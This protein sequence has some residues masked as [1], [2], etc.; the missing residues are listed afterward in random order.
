MLQTCM[1]RSTSPPGHCDKATAGYH[2]FLENGNL[3]FAE[4]PKS[5]P[6][7]A[8][9]TVP[10][11]PGVSPRSHIVLIPF[12][13]LLHEGSETVKPQKCWR[14]NMFS[15]TCWNL[16]GSYSPM[17]TSNPRSLQS[18]KVQWKAAMTMPRNNTLRPIAHPRWAIGSAELLITARIPSNT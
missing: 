3:Y 15:S 10:L 2:S 14:I 16:D 6:S 1:F 8:L 13:T 18:A 17:R 12:I 7:L 9:E 5:H 11:P 4:Y